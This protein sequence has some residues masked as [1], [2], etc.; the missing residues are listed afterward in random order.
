MADEVVFELTSDS[1]DV[2]GGSVALPGGGSL[3]LGKRLKDGKI[4]TSDPGE[5]EV[6][7]QFFAVQRVETGKKS[8]AGDGGKGE[9]E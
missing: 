7:D 8:K 2:E 4:K 6:L 5:I 9:G 3:D 1:K